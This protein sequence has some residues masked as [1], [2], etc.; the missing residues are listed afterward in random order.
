VVGAVVAVSA[1]ATGSEPTE[2]PLSPQPAENKTRAANDSALTAS[3]RKVFFL[4][5]FTIIMC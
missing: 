3:V 1:A 4:G 5:G 2:A